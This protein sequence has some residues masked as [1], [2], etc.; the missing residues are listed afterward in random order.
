MLLT[1]MFRAPRSRT[2]PF[3]HMPQG[4]LD[5]CEDAAH[6]HRKRLFE[7][8][9]RELRDRSQGE[10]PRVVYQHVDLAELGYRLLHTRAYSRLVSGICRDCDC[11]AASPN[12]VI[13]HLPRTL[14][15][16]TVGMA[17]SDPSFASRFAIAA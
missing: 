8:I 3:R 17:T 7:L 15:R 2:S 12:N 1:V 16:R 11:L 4:L 10:Q 6:I 13:E 14:L 5:G 9:G